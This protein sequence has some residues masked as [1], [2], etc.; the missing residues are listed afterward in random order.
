M[1]SAWPATSQPAGAVSLICPAAS[2]VLPRSARVK[3]VLTGWPAPTKSGTCKEN[4]VSGAALGKRVGHTR[5]TAEPWLGT[6][7]RR[8]PADSVSVPDHRSRTR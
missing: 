5:N 8:V 3:V 1:V 6:A 2:G 4:A 7:A